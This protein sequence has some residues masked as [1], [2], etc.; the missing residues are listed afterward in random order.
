MAAAL[1][2]SALRLGLAIGLVFGCGLA[3]GAQ[4]GGLMAHDL[5]GFALDM[6]VD[7]VAS[8]ANRP[9]TPTG[10]GQ[11]QVMIDGIDYSF[12]FSS[13]GHLFRIDSRQQLVPFPVD[14]AFAADLTRRLTRKFGQPMSN[15]LPAGPV[16]WMYQESYVGAKGEKLTRE[17]ES[18]TVLVA[19]GTTEPVTVEMQ[20]IA[21][22]IERRDAQTAPAAAK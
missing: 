8:V 10:T 15:Q 21:P 18:L 13:A 22:R 3:A 2:T 17:T 11:Y 7:Q 14:A 1:A 16:V 9:L 5:S 19:G 6:T 20:M 4:Q 12:G